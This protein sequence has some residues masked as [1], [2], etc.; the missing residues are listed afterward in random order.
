MNY[1][2]ID[3]VKHRNIFFMI[4]AIITLLGIITLAIFG[5]NL[6]VEFKS[7][8]S[9]DITLNKSI[10]QEQ[11]IN[12]YEE[13]GFTVLPT[14]GGSESNRISNRFDI[15]LN[16]AQRGSIINAFSA[17]NDGIV[18]EYEENTV[19]AG[20]A[21]EFALRAIWVVAVASIGIII[22]VSIRF[23]WRFAI[24]AII[25]LLHDA[26]LVISIFSIFRFEINLAFI[27]AILTIIGYSVNDTIVIFDRIRENLRFA[28][29]KSFDDLADLVNKSIR[30]TFTRSINTALTVIFA[31]ACLYIFGSAAIKLFSLALLI[32]LFFGAYSS[33]FI[34]SQIWLL[35][36]SKS[37]K[38]NIRNSVD[39]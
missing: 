5:L 35:M 19:D 22:Y 38:K 2:K 8:T 26:F 13:V 15:V 27:A 11:A 3:F 9:L 36:K 7:G 18:A 37:L 1:N 14:I 20:M 16:D 32:G 21:Q 4:S 34:A 23:E 33:I 31:A 17:Y 10:T 25:A 6:G 28:K 24:T 12:I 29:L 30:Q 39:S